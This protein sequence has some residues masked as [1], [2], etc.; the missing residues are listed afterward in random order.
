MSPHSSAFHSIFNI[1]SFLRRSLSSL[2]AARQTYPHRASRSSLFTFNVSGKVE[3]QKRRV[4]RTGHETNENYISVTR[5]T[6]VFN[7]TS[8][9]RVSIPTLILK[10][11]AYFRRLRV[12]RLITLQWRSSSIVQSKTE[13]EVTTSPL[14]YRAVRLT[15]RGTRLAGKKLK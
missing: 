5:V 4:C 15:A 14:C 11:R 7:A 9:V 6:S 3:R 10:T 13:S 2:S 8:S 1:I 12:G